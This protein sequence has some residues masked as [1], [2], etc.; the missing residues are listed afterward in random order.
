MEPLILL[1]GGKS[2]RHITTDGP[3]ALFNFNGKPWIECQ[4]DNFIQAGGNQLI[5]VLGYWAKEIGEALINLKLTKKHLI[6]NVVNE[7]PELGPFSSLQTGLKALNPSTISGAFIL[8]IDVP[9]P[10]SETFELLNKQIQSQTNVQV[11]KPSYKEK[12]GHPVWLAKRTIS[13]LLELDPKFS[14]LDEFIRSLPNNEIA[15]VP[16][17]EKWINLNLNYEKDFI[18]YFRQ[19]Y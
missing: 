16:V 11:I 9:C 3:K 7:H 1:A 6:T 13:K 12:N 2:S 8:P 5:V 14:R 18:E 4:I 19:R 15:I 17:N 10:Q